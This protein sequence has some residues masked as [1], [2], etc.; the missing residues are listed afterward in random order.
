MTCLGIFSE[1]EA[2]QRS[3]Q[4][5]IESMFLDDVVMNVETSF[6]LARAWQSRWQQRR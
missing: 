5:D 6:V 1:K 4:Y 2:K 3:G